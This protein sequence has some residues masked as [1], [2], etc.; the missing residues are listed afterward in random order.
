[1]INSE[2]IFQ[3]RTFIHMSEYYFFKQR[4]QR[5]STTWPLFGEYNIS[6][7]AVLYEV[8]ETR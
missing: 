3:T 7:A 5:G 8:P 1:M 2:L 4:R 6:T